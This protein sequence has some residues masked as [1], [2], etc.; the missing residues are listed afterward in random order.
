MSLSN[1]FSKKILLTF[2]IFVLI[3][4]FSYFLI[5]FYI[6]Y[7][8]LK[9]DHSCG[10]HQGSLPNTWDT[11]LDIQN[12]KINKSIQLRKDFDSKK[13]H[14][15]KWQEVN[16]SSNEKNINISGWLFNY[17]K[18]RPIV[19]IVH[20]I[21]PNGKC[22]P[23]SNLIASLLIKNQINAL[24][25]DLRNYGESTFVNKYENLG[26]TSYKD[27][28]GAYEFLLR[29]GFE[30]N[31]IGLLGISLGA[32]STIFAA[33]S[34]T[35]IKAVW[36]DS[37]IS[38]FKLILKDEIARYGFSHDFGLAVSFAG[39]ILSG[40][41]P[42]NLSPAFSL[43]KEQNY[44]FTHGEKDLRVLPHHFQYLKQYSKENKIKADFWL[45]PDAYHVDSILMFPEEYGFKMKNFFE[46][47]LTN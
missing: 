5:G 3:I 6:A 15:N 38:E 8:I 2:F 42:Y 43:T 36:V 31:E 35:K 13:Y 10:A 9:I 20:G 32:T 24:T 7:N 12:Y 1:I 40:I 30:E 44:F 22:K 33:K 19:I 23:E 26:L 14:L 17:Y 4:F 34:N 46:T 21:F 28:L 11:S 41:D 37:S 16:F 27:V 45:V 47:H 29:N 18:N 39:K 25:I